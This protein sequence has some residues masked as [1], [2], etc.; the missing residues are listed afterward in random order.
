MLIAAKACISQGRELSTD[1]GEEAAGEA[2]GRQI[3][4]NVYGDQG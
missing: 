3:L 4:G 2:Q 1:E